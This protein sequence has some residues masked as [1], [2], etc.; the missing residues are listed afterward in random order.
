MRNTLEKCYK[1]EE[2]FGETE[3]ALNMLDEL[4]SSSS[5]LKQ[6]EIPSETVLSGKVEEDGF[7][8]TIEEKEFN[9]K[10]PPGKLLLVSRE[11]V[12][13]MYGAL[14]LCKTYYLLL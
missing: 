10:C 13:D 7:S 8:F 1:D 5:R 11:T 4:I 3:E 6:C 14:E 2:I 12:I 9:C